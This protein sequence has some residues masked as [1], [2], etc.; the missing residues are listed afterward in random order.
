MDYMIHIAVMASL[1]VILTSS[2]NLLIGYAGLFALAHAGFFAVGAY[3]TAIL[4][5]SYGLPFP[6]P[7]LIGAALTACVGAFI[8]MPALR[9]SGHYLVIITLAFQVILLAFLLNVKS[10]TGGADGITGIERVN[11]FGYKLRTSLQFL[12]LALVVAVLCFW[13]CWRVANSPFGRALRAMRE[14]EA[15]TEAV[16]KNI[17]YMKVVV[18]MV[19]SALAAV[20]GSLYARYI[21]FVGVDTFSI[22][23]TIY[24]LA[25]VI[26]GGMANLWGSIVGAVILVLLP[27][28]LKFLDLP[29]DIADKGREII[30]GLMLIIILRVRPEGIWPESQ[31]ATTGGLADKAALLAGKPALPDHAGRDVGRAVTVSGKNLAKHFGGIVAVDDFSIELKAGTIIGLIGPNGAGKTTAFNLLTGFLKPTRGEIVYRGKNITGLKPHQVVRAGMARSFQDLKLFTRM[32]V[33]EN[34]MVALPDQ[35]G[36]SVLSLFLSPGRVRDE[37]VENYARAI[38]ILKFVN[39]ADKAEEKA[40]NLSYAEEKLLVVARL[41]ATG[42]DVLLFDEPLSGLDPNTLQEI[43]PVIRKLAEDGKT[44]C[45]IEHNLDVIKGVCDHVVFLDEGRGLAEGGPDEL[46]A[47]P[48]LAERYFG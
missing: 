18:F 37:E 13:I 33:L 27:E 39:L 26:L 19:G 38:E 3:A 2:F 30:Y 40:E 7:L 44:V 48:A 6:V 17:L 10:L 22:D 11:F 41:L 28:L 43:F 1:Y 46:L 12:P 5:V 8:A 34:V 23:E 47:N 21:T 29:P 42:A 25:M 15:A 20:A 24:I 45:I 14:N 4:S 31:T 32:T 35:H 16:G 36:D 9:T